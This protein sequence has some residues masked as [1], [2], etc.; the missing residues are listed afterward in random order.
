VTGVPDEKSPGLAEFPL[1][2]LSGPSGSGKT[3]IVDR[4]LRDAPVQIYKAVS[5][6]TRPARA[7]EVDGDAYYFLSPAEFERRRRQGEFIEC[8]E[9]HGSGYW[10]GT[11]KSELDRAQAAGAW[12]LLEI[13]VA[14]ALEVMR[15]FPQAVT[16]FLQSSSEAEYERRLR[17]RG[18]ESEDAIARRLQ[19]ARKELQS[20][21]RYA[22]RVV[23]DDLDEAVRRICEILKSRETERHAG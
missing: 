2:V 22:F 15:Q 6:T 13:D 14:G 1:V 11:L 5:A 17:R 12:A 16:I 18:T 19:T 7:G 10:Y 8:A 4:L 9:V 20:A 21:D 3:T 23:N